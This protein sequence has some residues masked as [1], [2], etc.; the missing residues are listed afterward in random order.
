MKF[1]YFLLL[2]VVKMQCELCEQKAISTNPALCPEHFDTFFLNTVKKT[3]EEY[4]L[5][6]VKTK[7]CVAVSGGKD[8]LALLD[9]LTRLG[10]A[11]EGLFIHE[12]IAH[13]R[14]ASEADLDEFCEKNTIKVRKVSFEEEAG[15]T[16]DTAMETKKFHSCTLCGTLRRYLLNKYAKDYDVIA[17]GHNL[18]D[19]AQTVLINLARGNTSLFLRQ[20][21]ST[22]A[23]EHF[24]RKI[25]PFSFLS[26]KH[27]LTYVVLRRIRVDFAECPYARQSYRAHLR[28]I[29]NTVEQEHPGTKKNIIT[30][31]LDLKEHLSRAKSSETPIQTCTRCGQASGE[32]VC[33]ACQLI[34]KVH[35]VLE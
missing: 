2:V 13:Y 23:S 10:Y 15:F 12:G 11:V 6:S 27:I 24:V 3:I 33:K 29:L 20:G 18:D 9:V 22:E 25:K 19:E 26:E 1:A 21:V 32:K 4:D 14:E 8:S 7:I 34:A 5:C 35:E 16:L 31:Y 30:T 17:T 28:D